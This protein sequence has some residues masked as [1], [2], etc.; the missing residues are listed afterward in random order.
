MARRR[1]LAL[2]TGALV[3]LAVPALPASAGG[4]G[5]HEGM[6]QGSGDAV[7]IA[8][9]CFTPGIL[10]VEP[11]ASVAFS[12]KDPYPH[13][14]SANGWGFLEGLDQGDG[15]SATFDTPGVYPFACTYH[16]SM[17][18]AVV[19]G[20]GTGAGN[21]SLVTVSALETT[22]EAATEVPAGPLAARS[23]PPGSSTL[24]W[25]GGGAIGLV[26]GAV[27]GTAASRRRRPE[28]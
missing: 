25:L 7:V 13:N 2:A 22:A 15:F 4:G 20:D 14:V 16:P 19:V 8:N 11:G 1:W 6:T 12:N 18:G 26:A 21:G 23:E 28:G 17:T 27:V 3:W 10:R 5:C 9:G 24:G